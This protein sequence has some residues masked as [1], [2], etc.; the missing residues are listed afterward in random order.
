MAGYSEFLFDDI[1]N[2]YE[3]KNLYLLAVARLDK[4]LK[5]SGSAAAKELRE[6][7]R[8]LVQNRVKHP[9]NVKLA[10]YT[11]KEK[12]FLHGLRQKK[13]DY[14][15]RLGSGMPAKVKSL[16]TMLYVNQEKFEFYRNYASLCYDAQLAAGEA[17]LAVKQLP[18][19]IRFYESTYRDLQDALQARKMIDA[20]LER[21]KRM[22]LAQEK[23]EQTRALKTEIQRLRAKRK[24]GLISKK[25]EKN[26]IVGLKL[27]YREQVSA[28]SYQLPRKSNAELIKKLRFNL[29]DG[30]KKMLNVLQAD[31]ADLRRKTPVETCKRRAM[32]A[33]LTFML[34]GLGQL[35]NGQRE[36]GLAFLLVS[37]FTYFVAVPYALGYGNYQGD[38]IAGLIT[39]AEG[40]PRIY[41]SLIFMIE[42]I[43]ALLLLIIALGLVYASFRDVLK[44][45]RQA[46]MGVRPR[47]WY[48]TR[49]HIRQGGFPYIVSLPALF[50]IVFIVL[51]PV[52]TTILVSFTGM[53]PQHQARFSW[54]GLANYQTLLLGRGLAGSV[55]WQILSWTVVWTLAASTLAIA[56]G[57]GL[58][59]LANNERVRGKKFFR[60]IYLL[61]WA[62]P[63]FIT[64]MFFSIMFS[65]SGI[66]TE[67]LTELLG[68]RV[69]V[70][71]DPQLTRLTL[72]LIQGWLGSSYV[73]LLTTGVLQAIPSDLYEAADIDG[74]TDWQK[75]RRIT[76][77]IVLFQ[78]APLLITQYTF[79][80]NNFSIIYLF[81]SGGPF[82][83]SRYGNLAGASDILISYI[84]KLTMVNQQQ[85]IGAAITVV[86][87]LGLMA[88]A[89]VGFKNTKAFKEGRL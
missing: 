66:L 7:R 38:G 20:D 41:Q 58:A 40:G 49:A 8:R 70:K 63:A 12:L 21:K 16:K 83:P 79:N 57:F 10:D 19:V 9:Y 88:F 42:G 27:Q 44:V 75:T 13:K 37:F 24:E 85:A 18:E 60:T 45:E 2:R 43:I 77:P 67:L 29:S 89:Y 11:A 46:I 62:V 31:I 26:G 59:L 48:E 5:Q 84:F 80:F 74:A 73:F 65:P 68:G 36:K 1:G 72:V 33:Y 69:H 17:E 54:I 86:I 30:T 61:P 28:K 32:L 15:A 71:T 14:Y 76:I 81:N 82:N 39:L 25:A 87:S 23:K 55:F 47:N 64:I 50:V 56:I 35:L 22:E 51:V 3:R 4:E 6:Q 78:T 53:S 52:A 34:P